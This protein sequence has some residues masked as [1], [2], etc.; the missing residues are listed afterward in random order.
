AITIAGPAYSALPKHRASLPVLVLGDLAAG[1][2]LAE[3]LLG[4][5]PTGPAAVPAVVVMPPAPP[6]EEQRDH[7]DPQQRE[8]REPPVRLVSDHRSDHL[9]LLRVSVHS[10]LAAGA[11]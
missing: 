9:D 10:M 6:P 8:E 5:R 7:A 1:V 4:G 11:A 3:D 2:S